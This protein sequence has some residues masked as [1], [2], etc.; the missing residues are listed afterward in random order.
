MGD[1]TSVAESPR[2]AVDR[3][4]VKTYKDSRTEV[5]FPIFFLKRGGAYVKGRGKMPT[6][7]PACL[8]RGCGVLSLPDPHL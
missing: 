4:E 6:P 8:P 1:H 5:L 7:V 2:P 3:E